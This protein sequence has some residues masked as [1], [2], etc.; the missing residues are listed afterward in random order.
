M[1]PTKKRE[2]KKVP[3]YCYQCVNGPDLLMVE[4]VDGIATRV[5]PNFN[6]KGSHPAEGKVCVKP[7]GI[8]Q[9]LYNPN[10]IL[11]P[12]KRTNPKKGRNEDP[13]WVE[14]SWDEAL[15]TVGE[16]LRAIRARGLVDENGDPR[17]AFTTGGA[18][19]P[20][21]YAGSLGAF[22]GAWGPL[23]ASLG[24]GGTVKCYHSEHVFGEL[25]H[26]AFTVL[27][28]TPRCEYVIAFGQNIDASGGVTAVYRQANAR[29]RGW[30]RIQFEP[31][32]SVT[33]AKATEWIPIKT[34]TDGAVMYAMLHVMLHERPVGDLDVQF[35]KHHTAAPY[36]I[37]PNHY[38]LRDP[39]SR[40][41][42]VWDL[43]SNRA[44][45]FD[46][47]GID[48]ALDG[49]FTVDRCVEVGADDDAW[50]HTG[51]SAA[52]AFE[53][54]KEHVKVHTPEWAAPISDVAA[55]KIR[56]VANE[57][58]DHARIGETIDIAGRT[59]PFRPVA[60]LLGKSVNNG[61]GAYECVWARTVMQVLVGALEVPGGLLGSTSLVVGPDWDRW[62][63]VQAGEDG[64]MTNPA[65]P[66]DR[67]HWVRQR[68]MRHAFR[69][70]TPMVGS[71]F[72]APFLGSTTLTWMR[73]QG[74]AAQNWGKP[75]PPDVWFVYK[76][77]PAISFSETSRLG[78]TIAEFPFMVAFAYT[79][80]ETNHF[81]DILLPDAIDL[82]SDQLIR[83]GG[84]HYFE[85]QW[86]AEG[87]V[88]R[89]KAVEPLGEAKDFS[90]ICN[91]LAQRAGILEQYNELINI[92]AC[93]IPLKTEA[94]DFSLPT[95]EKHSAEKVWDA[96]CRAASSDLTRG[97][98]VNGLDWFREHGFKIRPFSN[99]QWFLFPK[100]VDMGLRFELPF[101]E[102]VFRTGQQ[103]ARRL[104]ET[105]VDW[106][107][108]QLEE[109]E[110]LPRWKDLNKLWD[111]MLERNY[112][113]KA[114]DYPI[115][116]LSAR[117]MQYAWGGNVGL[118][119]IQEVASNVAGHDGV[120]INGG[121]AAQLGIAEGDWIEIESP[122]G[123]AF[124]RA[125]LRQG[126]RPDV[127]LMLGQFGHWKTP[128]AKDMKVPGLNDLVPMNMDFLDGSGSS[129]DG[130]KVKVRRAEVQ[131]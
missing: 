74:R 99:L 104:H 122:V 81:A 85:Q 52:S 96:V 6:A 53:A 19:T 111:D 21:F 4:V 125:R 18:G 13:G 118:Q 36:L 87:W 14:I 28:D 49:I 68:E 46:T 97:K 103:L 55:D 102:R 66:T 64:F 90:W 42:L 32:L 3:T 123:K 80:D 26:R 22:L 61:W 100:L 129:I 29:A 92:G 88:L 8:V 67:E 89:Q 69:S 62:A 7:Y 45:P 2:V 41:P 95:T 33:G 23:D 24:A 59:L 83:L 121:K 124:G 114:A 1:Q 117:S 116:L 112:P 11:K 65:N 63:S 77:N 57:F 84:T 91:E 44:V 60:V 47:P 48:P 127:V 58:V 126:I 108:R 37:G 56:R 25:W 115:W 10:R 82:E 34:K 93:G 120:L 54:L 31:H 73:L 5:E 27:P 30:K 51:I 9:K 78:E 113:V 20:M 119:M 72:Y 75:K 86:E 110:P 131:R 79:L 43:G 70:L 15:D 50:E 105:G 17:F 130:T 12:M 98:E 107:E 128:F 16:R 71:Q 94:W 40:K 106:W 76:C 101:Q 38:F 35:L 39:A 109:Y